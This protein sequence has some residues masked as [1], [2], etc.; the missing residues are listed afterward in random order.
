MVGSATKGNIL[1]QRPL[2]TTRRK[3]H[4]RHNV[5]PWALPSWPSIGAGT[6]VRWKWCD[7]GCSSS[8]DCDGGR[9]GS[10][11]RGLL[12]YCF[13]LVSSN[14]AVVLSLD[15]FEW[16]RRRLIDGSDL[17]RRALMALRD[18]MRWT[19]AGRND[20]VFVCTYVKSGTTWTQQIITLVSEK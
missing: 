9:A 8:Q 17:A 2:N 7:V 4:K 12:I 16:T 20:D 6:D 10:T 14:T 1:C 15:W 13:L 18:V 19:L 5:S 3:R 11:R